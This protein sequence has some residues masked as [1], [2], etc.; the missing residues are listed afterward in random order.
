MTP[1]KRLPIC[2]AKRMRWLSPPG[3]GVRFTVKGEVVETYAVKEAEP[4]FDFFDDL[5][6]D[7]HASI[8]KRLQQV[9]KRLRW[10]VTFRVPSPDQTQGVVNRTLTHFR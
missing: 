7:E 9:L 4:P 2:V 5:G 6:A 1:V 3:Q 10:V 8:V